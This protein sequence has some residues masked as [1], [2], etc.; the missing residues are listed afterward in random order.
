MYSF[1]DPR[2]NITIPDEYGRLPEFNPGNLL[3]A[4]IDQGDQTIP[5]F[6]RFL[7]RTATPRECSICAESRYELDIE[8]VDAWRSSC[9][10]FQ[11]PW[12]W[13]VLLFPT[14]YSLECEH[15]MDACKECVATHLSTQ[16]E[17]FGV[18]GCDRLSCL[19]CS[20][21]LTHREV[22]LHAEPDTFQK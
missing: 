13:N 7:R 17:E 20:R 6:T 5:I 21:L 12:M 18:N 16:L 15:E 3:L 8:N 14:K 19:T 4:D 1:F 11:G 10:G 2:F 9:Q 22:K